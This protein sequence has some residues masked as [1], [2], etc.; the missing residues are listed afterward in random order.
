M[1]TINNLPIKVFAD[2]ASI[3]EFI[4]LNKNPIIKGFTTNPSLMKNNGIVDYSLFALE[5]LSIIKTKPISFEVFADELEEM[6]EQAFKINSWGEN[7]Y[8]KI[9][10]TNTKGIS[11]VPL[12]KHLQEKKIKLNITA[13][14]SKEQIQKILFIL[15][16]DIPSII[17]IFCG[18]IADTGQD[19]GKL[20][21][22][23]KQKIKKNSK[24]EILWASTREL[25]NIFQANDLGTDIIT[26]PN[27]LL[28]KLDL[29]GKNL[30]E[31][32]LETVKS[33]YQDAKS[34]KYSI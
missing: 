20:I 21:R 23:A 32:S 10:V 3:K 34:S 5:L 12:I 17:S 31:Y 25:L 28:K 1:N 22:F 33:F 27:E 16:E 29:I 6:K 30:D 9:P 18:R 26:V 13:V 4:N 7:V 19:P 14:F 15:K 24:I 11:V 2:G 8:V